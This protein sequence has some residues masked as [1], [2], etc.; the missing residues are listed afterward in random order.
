MRA[1]QRRHRLQTAPSVRRNL[2]PRSEFSHQLVVQL[3]PRPAPALL[4]LPDRG[5]RNLSR[6][7]SHAAGRRKKVPSGS[8]DYAAELR[9]TINMMP[10]I[11]LS[12]VHGQITWP[13]FNTFSSACGCG[14][15]GDGTNIILCIVK[16]N[17]CLFGLFIV[18]LRTFKRIMMKVLRCNM[19]M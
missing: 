5:N 15:Y 10:R 18:Y 6:A 7:N 19:K 17:H 2:P 4:P 3:R 16:R 11:M 1:S 8:I 13:F 14:L 9:R 12:I